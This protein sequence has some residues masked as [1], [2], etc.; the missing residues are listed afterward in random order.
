MRS[1][2]SAI[3]DS[4][5]A[6]SREQRIANQRVAS[7]SLRQNGHI[8]DVILRARPSG[9]KLVLPTRPSESLMSTRTMWSPAGS[10]TSGISMPVGCTKDL[11][12]GVRSTFGVLQIGD[13]DRVRIDLGA[14][15]GFKLELKMHRR[16]HRLD[17]GDELDLRTA[18]DASPVGRDGSL[19]R[20]QLGS[21]SVIKNLAPHKPGSPAENAA[22]RHNISSPTQQI[23]HDHSFLLP[24]TTK[25]SGRRHHR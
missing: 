6:I 4:G 5:T 20:R 13:L 19:R 1:S 21:S 7:F 2:R 12:R 23:S 24:E 17:V 10:C 15:I 11:T 8:I 16:M 3:N 22:A 9:Q 25:S 14:A 18:R